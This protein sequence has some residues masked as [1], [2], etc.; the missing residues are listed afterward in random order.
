MLGNALGHVHQMC[1]CTCLGLNEASQ[2]AFF[3]DTC[4]CISR[5]AQPVHRYHDGGQADA[6]FC[7]SSLS[8]LLNNFL[9][10]PLEPPQQ[11][12]H[13]SMWTHRLL[14]RLPSKQAVALLHTQ[15]IAP[16]PLSSAQVRMHCCVQ[17]PA[18]SLRGNG[19][20]VLHCLFADVC[21]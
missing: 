3:C 1:R 2:L 16:V 8:I 5:S 19:R 18:Q 9:P 10:T 21:E 15:G 17:S 20:C 6:G 4:K 11:Q 7:T 14:R 13:V 12:R